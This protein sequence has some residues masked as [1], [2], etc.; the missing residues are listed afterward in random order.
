MDD[1]FG[2][3]FDEEDEHLDTDLDRT[4]QTDRAVYCIDPHTSGT[5]LRMELRPDDGTDRPTCVLSRPSRHA[6][7]DSRAQLH[8][9]REESEDDQSFSLLARLVRNIHPDEHTDDLA[10]VFDPMMDFSFDHFSKERI[11][12]LLE[13]LTR[14]RTQLV[15]EEHPAGC[16]DRPACV[17]LLTA[18]EQ[19]HI[20]RIPT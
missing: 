17:L 3:I 10:S 7:T 12:K 16:S 14:A 9:G 8:L 2:P 1:D 15:H 18:M 4:D 11:F 6:K 5:A 19:S 13:D 20:S